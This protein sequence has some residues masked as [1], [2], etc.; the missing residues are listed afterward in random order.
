MG[1][2]FFCC[3]VCDRSRSCGV[4]CGSCDVGEETV[5]FGC[6]RP[7]DLMCNYCDDDATE[8]NG[9]TKEDT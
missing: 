8:S 9:I 6:G 4:D 2:R 7:F 5:C 1:E 3:E